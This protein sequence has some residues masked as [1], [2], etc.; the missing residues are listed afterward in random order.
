MSL[1][2]NE[3]FPSSETETR[4]TTID[5]QDLWSTVLKTD[6]QLETAQ[7]ILREWNTATTLFALKREWSTR[8]EHRTK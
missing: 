4:S 1:D 6:F 5:E 3:F 7:S 8:H 2:A